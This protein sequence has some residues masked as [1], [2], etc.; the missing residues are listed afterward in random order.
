MSVIFEQI[1]VLFIFG[2]VGFFLSKTK[3]VN[4]DHSK[5][6]SNLL[7]YFVLPCNIFKTYLKNFNVT[8]IKQRYEI[9]LTGAVLIIVVAVTMH[10]FAKLFSKDKY[11]RSVFEYTLTIPN[12]GYMGYALA[13]SLLGGEGL[14]NLM[15][16]ALPISMYT[17][18]YGFCILTKRSLEPKKLLNPILVSMILGVV[19]GLSGLVLPDVAMQVLDKSSACLSALGMLLVGIVV[20]E[21][22][23]RDII[24]DVR[25]FVISLMRLVAIP[26]VIGGILLLM[27]K[28]ETVETVVLFL[29]IPCGVNTIVFPKLV[30]ENCKLGAGFAL[31][32][33]ILACVT[34]PVVYTLFGIG[35]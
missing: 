19:A 20:S 3:L 27:C 22:K 35:G 30:D 32:S 26:C 13:E 11:E 8:Y 18:T 28:P 4:R 17:Y 23:P 33:N 25:I 1:F 7:V 21:F 5:I 9:V 31:V 6:I 14:M 29:A 10:F 16:L 15:V 2:A 12:Y 34:V 24:G